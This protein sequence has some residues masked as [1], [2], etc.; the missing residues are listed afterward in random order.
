MQSAPVEQNVGHYGGRQ[1]HY[2][3]HQHNNNQ[4]YHHH[5]QQQHQYQPSYNRYHYQNRYSA[6]DRLQINHQPPADFELQVF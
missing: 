1:Q 4:H 2:H 3:H 6:Q 5:Q